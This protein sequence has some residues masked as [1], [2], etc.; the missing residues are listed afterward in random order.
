MKFGSQATP[1]SGSDQS[2][3]PDPDTLPPFK[4]CTLIQPQATEGPYLPRGAHTGHVSGVRG[5]G[6]DGCQGRNLHLFLS[7]QPWKSD[8]YI[9]FW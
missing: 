6:G 5:V 8:N 2:E 3:I 1:G 7:V 4:C 9:P